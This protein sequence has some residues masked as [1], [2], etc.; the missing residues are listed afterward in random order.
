MK[1]TSSTGPPPARSRSRRPARAPDGTGAIAAGPVVLISRDAALADHVSA[2][3]QAAGGRLL[4]QPTAA[5]P[6]ARAA[7]LLLIGDDCDE[8]LPRARAS[9]VLVTRVQG[10]EAPDGIWRRAMELGADHV[11]VLP[12]GEPWLLERLIDAAGPVPRAPLLAA[13]GG[14]G[15]AGAST[16]AVALAA[17]AARAGRQPVLIDADPFGGGLDLALGMEVRPGPRWNDLPS[18]PGRLPPGF[19]LTSLPEAAG[20]RLLSCARHHGTGPR[21]D[22][23]SIVLEAAA[24]DADVVIVDLPRRVTEVEQQVLTAAD[25]VLLV[26]P[27]EVRATAAAVHLAAGLQ[28]YAA[29]L[30]LVVRGPAPTGLDPATVVEACTLPLQGELAA[31]KGL[32]VALDRGEGAG[33][34]AGGPLSRLARG[35][36]ADVLGPA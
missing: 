19:L 30:R 28:G 10:P 3:V 22:Q 15:G 8:P 21:A 13:V 32:A 16:L 20:I 36:L 9:V 6:A 1:L 24:R 29:D 26:V 31:E 18:G 34:A 27:A 2:L 33:I 12:E 35:V 5:G 17:T 14:R 4:V 25:R 23:M 11:A 7:A